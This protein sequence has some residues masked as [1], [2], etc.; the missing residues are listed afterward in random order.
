MGQSLFR[1]QVFVRELWGGFT[2]GA[3]QLNDGVTDVLG[4]LPEQG[5]RVLDTIIIKNKK[6]Q[7]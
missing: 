1:A 5:L 2:M 3:R 4:Q 6:K 7:I